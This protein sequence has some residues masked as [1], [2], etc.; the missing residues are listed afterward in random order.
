MC[1]QQHIVWCVEPGFVGD[2]DVVVVVVVCDD[3]N[4]IKWCSSC[5]QLHDA[6]ASLLVYSGETTGAYF[7]VLKV[8]DDV[9]VVVVHDE[10]SFSCSG[11]AGFH[12]FWLMMVVQQ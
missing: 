8:G 6:A 9:V 7:G 11:D 12:G 10:S 3:D 1:W 4:Q 2:D 5:R